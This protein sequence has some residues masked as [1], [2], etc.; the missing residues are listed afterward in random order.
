MKR[1]YPRNNCITSATAAIIVLMMLGGCAVRRPE[2]PPSAQMEALDR[3]QPRQMLKAAKQGQKPGPPPFSEQMAPLSKE[4]VA[5]PALYSL[6]FDK[7]PL[8]DVIAALTRDSENNLSIETEVDLAKSVTVNL[9]NVT[10]DEALDMIVI[11][12]AGY[13]WDLEKGTLHIKRFMERIYRLNFLDMV[14]ETDIDVGGDMLG[15]GVKEA[16]VSGKYQVKAKK[17]TTSSDLWEAVEKA[18][19]GMRSG[20]GLLRVNRNAGVIYM[21]DTPRKISAM[22]RFLDSLSESLNRQV[23]IEARIMQVVLSDENKYGIDWTNLGVLFSDSQ[24]R[25]PDVFEFGFNGNGIIAKNGTSGFS[26]LLDYLKTQGEVKILSNPH[27]LVMNRQSALLTVGRQL[28]YTEIDGVDRDEE[29]NT[30]TI[31]ASIRR[32]IL[33]LQ[34]GITPQ[35]SADGMITLHIVPTLTRVDQEVNIAIP[36]GVNS[37]QT[38]SNPVIDLQELVTMVRVREGQ[39]FVLAGL[40][41]KIRN[42]SEEGLPVLGDMP[43]LGRLFQHYVSKEES[44]ELVIFITPYI[45]D[46]GYAANEK[47]E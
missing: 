4:I 43:W 12:G 23:F 2:P 33:G 20:E 30:V 6:V 3:L 10:L 7:A 28:P 36:T 38:I 11:N 22:V 34:L 45:V 18:L 24:G 40:I 42:L 32:A 8:G 14:G 26:A 5:A 13:A 17:P 35:I 47:T 25:L 1:Q 16:G 27:L 29:T 19:D 39:S 46:G 15:S 44:S 21:A 41:S 9:K 37:I 31:G